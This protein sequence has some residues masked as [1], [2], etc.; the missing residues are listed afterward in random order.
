MAALTVA[1]LLALWLALGIW[2][3]VQR[4]RRDRDAHDR[5]QLLLDRT[6]LPDVHLVAVVA[7]EWVNPAGQAATTVDVKDGRAG[8]H[9]FPLACFPLGSLVLINQDATNPRMLDWMPPDEVQAAH[10]HRARHGR[11]RHRQLA[12]R[13]SSRRQSRRLVAEVEDALRRSSA[14]AVDGPTRDVATD[15]PREHPHDRRSR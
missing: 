9:W 15:H 8:C 6:C 11:R 13:A 5:L 2:R 1:C 7:T 10:R 12:P 14:T 4:P 3:R